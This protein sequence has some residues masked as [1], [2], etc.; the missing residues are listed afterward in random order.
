MFIEKVKPKV[1]FNGHMHSGG[2]K[3]YTF[4]WGT[5]YIYIDSSQQS[6]HYLVF[7]DLDEIE[8]WQDRRKIDEI[9]VEETAVSEKLGKVLG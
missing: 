3:V 2:Y 5:K 8:V 1:V 7:E 6:R 9:S 4:P